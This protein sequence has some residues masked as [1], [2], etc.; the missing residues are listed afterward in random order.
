M[1][2]I[3]HQL[4]ALAFRAV[5]LFLLLHTANTSI[6]YA[7]TWQHTNST[8]QLALGW[9]F[10]Y[11]A[12]NLGV[13]FILIFYPAFLAKRMIPKISDDETN[14]QTA[15][16]NAADLEIIAASLL[17]L[18]FLTQSFLDFSRL[19]TLWVS[20]QSLAVHWTWTPNH[21][22]TAVTACLAL[23]AALWLLFGI[24]GLRRLLHLARSAGIKES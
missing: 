20:S 7:V 11:N 10:L 17:G 8:V 24:R 15:S 6:F 23:L 13:A 1:K 12:I 19:F 4:I 5:G 14:Q 16:F 9:L 3:S 18:Y 2:M 21:I 22:A